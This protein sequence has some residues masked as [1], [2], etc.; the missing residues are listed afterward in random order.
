MYNSV[1]ND[2]YFRE[3]KALNGPFSAGQY[4][5]GIVLGFA[6][7]MLFGYCNMCIT[8]S[9]VKKNGG[10]GLSAI[11]ATQ[12]LRSLMNVIALAIVFF[13][14][15]LVPLPFYA[16]LLS[17]ATGLAIGNVFFV[18]RLTQQMKRGMYGAPTPQAE[19]EDEP[20]ESV[21]DEPDSEQGGD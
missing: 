8:R 1:R 12:F 3:V 13:T 21:P 5:F 7:G 14:R 18:W 9:A 19:T 17:C 20:W 11:T 4:A 15:N 2:R 16:T 6:L 10:N